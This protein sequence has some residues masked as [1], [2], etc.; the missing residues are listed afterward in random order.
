VQAEAHSATYVPWLM[1]HNDICQDSVGDIPTP[2]QFEANARA[3][4]E[5]LR[6]GLD[7]ATIYIVGMVDVPRLY[8]VAQDKKALG[9]VDCEVLWF[10]T[11]FEL[12]PCRTVLDPF[13]DVDGRDAMSAII[14]EYNNRLE[15]LVLEFDGHQ[16]DSNKYFYTNEIFEYSFGID[17]VSD[18]DC[19]HPSPEGQ[20]LLSEITWETYDGPRFQD[21]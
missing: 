3:A 5:I 18:L 17:H 12:F 13:L 7:G 2:D 1:G 16:E 14:G 9:I 11:L 19:F 6:D 15:D 10:L 21:W 8:T 20:R 4:L